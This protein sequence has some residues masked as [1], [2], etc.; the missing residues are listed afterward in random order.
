MQR[1]QE[2]NDFLY[3]VVKKL[4]NIFSK[5]FENDCEL[6]GYANNNNDISF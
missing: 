4:N 1:E 5:Y 2:R 6:E 3:Y